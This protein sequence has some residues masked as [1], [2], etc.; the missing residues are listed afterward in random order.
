MED[1]PE[2]A[3]EADL[4]PLVAT[5]ASAVGMATAD[6]LDLVVEAGYAG[7]AWDELQRRLVVRAFPDLELSIATGTI[8]R[9]CARAGV[10]LHRRAELQENPSPAEIAA[11]AV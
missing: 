7:P 5:T 10:R 2:A 9:R 3:V 4:L 6:L 8:Y 1:I 11:E